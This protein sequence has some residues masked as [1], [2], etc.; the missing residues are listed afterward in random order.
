MNNFI[1]KTV[2]RYTPRDPPCITKSLKSML[3]KK[4]RFFKSYKKNSYRSEDKDLLEAFR[5]ECQEA[6]ESAKTNYL[7]DLGNKLNDKNTHPKAYWK[8]INRVLDKSR[9]P[10]IPPILHGR[11]CIYH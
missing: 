3:R 1:P 2:K 8:I 7:S 6:V 4:N 10:R 11:W 5:K 9:A